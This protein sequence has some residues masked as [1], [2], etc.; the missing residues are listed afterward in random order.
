MKLSLH[1]VVK[2]S[3]KKIEEFTRE[4]GKSTSHDF[5]NCTIIIENDKGEN[6]E[7]DLYSEQDFTIE[8]LNS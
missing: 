2:I 8:N 1:K 7:I 5:K 6:F 3:I 4:N